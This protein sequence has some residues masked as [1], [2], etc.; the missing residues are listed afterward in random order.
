MAFAGESD[1]KEGRPR[2]A[3][4][5][6]QAL[7]ETVVWRKS[8]VGVMRKECTFRGDDAGSTGGFDESRWQRA[9]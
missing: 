4:R 7:G 2:G 6:L 3:R 5:P 9:I 8:A 1:R